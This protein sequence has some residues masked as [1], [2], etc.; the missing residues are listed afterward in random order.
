MILLTIFI[1]LYY[2][3]NYKIFYWF[4]WII[5]IGW[6]SALAFVIGMYLQIIRNLL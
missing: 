3:T 1:L 5:G 2:I 4:G 6:L